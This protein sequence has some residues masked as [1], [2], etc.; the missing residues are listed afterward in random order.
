MYVEVQSPIHERVNQVTVILLLGL[1]RPL[2]LS[3]NQEPYSY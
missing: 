3:G 1:W 2:Q